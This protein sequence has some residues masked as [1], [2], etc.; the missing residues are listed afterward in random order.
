MTETLNP[1]LPD[2]PTGLFA[3]SHADFDLLRE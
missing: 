1:I 2:I 3:T